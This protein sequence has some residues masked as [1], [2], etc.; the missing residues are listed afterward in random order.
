M[1]LPGGYSSSSQLY[2]NH[3]AS[4]VLALWLSNFDTEL[5]MIRKMV[6]GLTPRVIK[7]AYRVLTNCRPIA[8]REC[9]ICDYSGT[10]SPNGRPIRVDSR[11][12]NCGSS[13]RHRLFWL[14][15]RDVRKNLSEP[16]VHFAAEKVLEV[17]LRE[18]AHAYQTADLFNAADLKINIES[19]DLPDES[20]G[21][22]I[23]NHVLEH[24]DDKSALAEL[25]RV[26]KPGGSLI[27]SVPLVEGWVETYENPDIIDPDER[28]LHFGQFDHVRY[29]G[30]DFRQRLSVA[31]FNVEE[32]TAE[33]ADVVKF[34]L[35]RGEKIF[36]CRK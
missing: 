35:L 1:L 3:H 8:R 17:K 34:S 33:G 11:C 27:V 36:V 16:V 9:P 30:R 26:L 32:V 23:C 24:V 15:Y 25:F 28:E 19:I 5:T 7:D 6:S 20:V 14:W 29:Y 13:E 18:L 2:R 21:T 12:P 22:I 10:F 31:G 4:S